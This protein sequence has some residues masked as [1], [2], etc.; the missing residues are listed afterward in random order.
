MV[1][2]NID[3]KRNKSRPLARGY[4]GIR[5]K[6]SLLTVFIVS[7]A[8]FFILIVITQFQKQI[9]YLTE[10][11]EKLTVASL[12]EQANKEAKA[13]TVTLA[14]SLSGPIS[15]GELT[16]INELLSTVTQ[17]RDVVYVYLFDSQ[18]KVID[19]GRSDSILIGKSLE[20][21]VTKKTLSGTDVFLLR[22]GDI[23]DAAVPIYIG[24]KIIGGL[25]IGFSNKRVN[26]DILRER[27]IISSV[28]QKTTRNTLIFP[29]MISIT[30]VLLGVFFS[31]RIVAL[32]VKPILKLTDSARE[33]G[34]GNLSLK[35]DIKS[36]DEL[37][38]LAHSFNQMA[39]GLAKHEQ[40]LDVLHNSAKVLTKNLE[41]DV[42]ISGGLNT[43]REIIKASK[44]SIMLIK[45]GYLVVEGVFGWKPGEVVRKRS[46]TIG[47]G[48]AGLAAQRKESILVN[49]V[50]NSPLFVREGQKVWRGC[51]NLLC[52][53]MIH[54]NQLKGVINIQ[55]KL[56]GAPFTKTDLEYAEIIAS[57]MAI[58][59]SNIELVQEKIE[60][61]RMEVELKTAEAVQKTLLPKE[62]PS[63]EKIEFSSFFDPANE[64]G[65]DWFGYVTDKYANK[66]TI[67]IGDVS[68]HGA[69]AALIT[70]AV[71]SFV[72]TVMILKEKFI[73]KGSGSDSVISMRE[74]LDRL[75]EPANLLRLLNRIVLEIGQRQLLMSFFV[76]SLD[77]KSMELR[78]ANAGHNQPYLYR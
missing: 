42:L 34:K 30:L 2:N 68:G 60:K 48:I 14:K 64:T 5:E 59:L 67:F 49:D 45:D 56:D 32:L 37:E 71:N 61:T 28:I 43:I 77:L 18:G 10:S 70:A 62:D 47:E 39:A 27:E 40:E 1:E 54:E 20:D 66:L 23:L 7:V 16:Q 78:F 50:N 17:Q 11:A 4:F 36:G 3:P 75:F 26:S 6:Y 8:S 53:P 44:G 74:E 38:E 29:I 65:G 69:S 41:L 13:L 46:F 21:E 9:D 25:R 57:S 58:S 51:Q 22:H 76:C 63:N 52:I 24:K 33:I 19:D 15:N 35:V 55:D 31:S 73:E 72:K 12:Y